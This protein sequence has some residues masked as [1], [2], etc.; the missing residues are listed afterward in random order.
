MKTASPTVYLLNQA[1]G[2]KISFDG[3]LSISHSLTLK[4]ST[5]AEGEEASSDTVN[6]ARNEPDVVTLTIL[7]SDAASDAKNHSAALFHALAAAKK[8]RCLLKLVTR[9]RTYDNMLLSSLDLTEDETTPYGWHGTLTLT[10]VSPTTRKKQDDRSS[11]PDSPGTTKGGN[12]GGDS[13]S[14]DSVLLTI[15]R[16]LGLSMGN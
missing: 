16:E 8:A 4:L 5:D 13:S 9:T 11:T 2:E 10:R 15:F 3:V 1:S 12:L 6:G 7:T 14:P